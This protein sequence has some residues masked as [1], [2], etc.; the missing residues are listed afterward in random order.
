[1]PRLFMLLYSLAGPSMAGIGI[2]AV[3]TAGRDTL[4]PI[5]TAAAAGAIL[6]LPVAWLVARKLRDG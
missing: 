2:V 5:L 1:M 3:L 4:Q 6:A